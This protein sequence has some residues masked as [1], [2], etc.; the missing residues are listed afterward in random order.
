MNQVRM[1]NV[2]NQFKKI[3]YRQF[4]MKTELENRSKKGERS[5]EGKETETI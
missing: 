5:N 4:Q 3:F 2:K 1:L